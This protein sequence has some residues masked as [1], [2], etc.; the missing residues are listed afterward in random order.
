MAEVGGAN[1]RVNSAYW[2]NNP[3]SGSAFSTVASTMG[4][5][6]LFVSDYSAGGNGVIRALGMSVPGITGIEIGATSTALATM[7]LTLG[8]LTIDPT[9]ASQ[10]I[11]AI[12]ALPS[13]ASFAA[14]V[15]AKLASV[16]LVTLSRDARFITLRKQVSTDFNA[17]PV[18]AVSLTRIARSLAAVGPSSAT[19]PGSVTA[20]Y[21]PPVTSTGPATLTLKNPSLRFMSVIR[22]SLDS[23]GN[24]QGAPEVP[25]LDGTQIP[26]ATIKQTNL[27]GGTNV[28][29]WGNIL[30]LQVGGAGSASESVALSTSAPPSA[31]RYYLVGPGTSGGAVLPSEI[32][33]EQFSVKVATLATVFFYGLGPILDFVGGVG[34]ALKLLKGVGLAAFEDFVLG[35]NGINV[36]SNGLDAALATKDPTSAIGGYVDL[37]FALLGFAGGV[38]E[39]AALALGGEALAATVATSFAGLAVGSGILAMAD[40]D[41]TVLS[42]LTHT[43]IEA[44]DVKVTRTP[45]FDVISLTGNG[46]QGNSSGYR[47][48]GDV[49]AAGHVVYTDTSY[50]QSKTYF[51]REGLTSVIAQ[52]QI[53]NIA[54]LNDDDHIA[55]STRPYVAPPNSSGNSDAF[56]NVGLEKIPLGNLGGMAQT[57]RFEFAQTSIIGGGPATYVGAMNNSD[58][59]IGTSYVT[60]IAGELYN[61]R[62]AFRWEAGKMTALPVRRDGTREETMDLNNK[63]QIVVTEIDISGTFSNLLLIEGNSVSVIDKLTPDDRYNI[64]INDSGEIAYTANSVPMLYD[65]L[66]GKR[67]LSVPDGGSAYVVDINNQGDVVGIVQDSKAARAYPGLWR[68][69]TL[70]DLNMI[71]PDGS[72]DISR[73][74]SIGDGGHILVDTASGWALLRPRFGYVL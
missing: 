74:L 46:P 53:G 55:F 10:R 13:F 51:Y 36:N 23:N 68:E 61:V 72:P 40:F 56:L 35:L 19:V 64:A 69:G 1:L 9:E 48:A 27:I 25:K 3:I 24:V 21:K 60:P 41:A 52:D 57:L 12:K 31:F 20:T 32:G 6:L 37:A 4:A 45:A 54:V 30:T 44:V 73:A 59:V 17:L 15:A 14:H 16:D 7:M 2:M 70:Y 71:V 66:R 18:A 22:E 38:A 47:R 33:I 67:S 63:G 65:P 8:I 50:S 39:S 29:S 26:T 62:Q 49:N 58:V 5:Q 34:G 28:L 11:A 43:R 42:L